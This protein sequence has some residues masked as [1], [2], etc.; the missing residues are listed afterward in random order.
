M[1]ILTTLV[2][3]ETILLK[4]LTESIAPPWTQSYLRTLKSSVAIKYFT[5]SPFDDT[6]IDSAA[7]VSIDNIEESGIDQPEQQK[8]LS[9]DKKEDWKILCCVIDRTLFIALAVAYK[10]FDGYY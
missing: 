3:V 6:K 2:F 9:Q 10:F 8:K 5:F 1:L 4:L 7:T